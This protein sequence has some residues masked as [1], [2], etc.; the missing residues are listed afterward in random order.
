MKRNDSFI[1]KKVDNEYLLLPA[2]QAATDHLKPIVTN[3]FGAFIWEC[4][5]ENI[6]STELISMCN[7]RFAEGQSIRHNLES[8][9]Y[10]F[11]ATLSARDM[12]FFE[13][14]TVSKPSGFGTLVEI[15][16]IRIFLDVA[17]EGIHES[18]LDFKISSDQT[19]DYSVRFIN[20]RPVITSNGNLLVRSKDLFV[21]EN[22]TDYI[23]LYPSFKYITE[24]HITKN[25]LQTTI[26][27]TSEFN[28]EFRRELMLAI[29]TPFALMAL[30]RKMFFLHSASILYK[31]KAICFSAPSGTG[32]STH[33][34]LWEQALGTK[35]INGDL[36]LIALNEPVPVVYGTPWCGTSGIYSVEKY[37]LGAILHLKRSDE[38]KVT[39][40]KE[41]KKSLS[42][43][44]RIVTPLW[45]EKLL[46]LLLPLVN[47]CI[48]KVPS[49]ELRCTKEPS[50]QEV[51]K[52]YLDSVL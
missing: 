20:G 47:T 6:D 15:A 14:K 27:G 31:N 50:A 23:L 3:E 10:S 49:A 43:T 38:D 22:S 12:L 34:A 33:A 52:R 32:K 42:M 5:S 44:S 17:L 28:D 24:A 37:P 18:L 2:G 7:N 29:R 9:I 48:E 4:L 26:Y 30:S 39:E 16:G 41:Y 25:D 21:L 36:N 13:A 11:I 46:D 1:L 51:S 45:D 35:I 8:D 40:L 19:P